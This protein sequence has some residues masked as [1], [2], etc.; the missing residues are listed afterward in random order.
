[1]RKNIYIAPTTEM[2]GLATSQLLETVIPLNGSVEKADPGTDING[3]TTE[4]D[5]IGDGTTLQRDHNLWD[6]D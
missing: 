2:V 5:A 3:N 4:W 6:E 1:M